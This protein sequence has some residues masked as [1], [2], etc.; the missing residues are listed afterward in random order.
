MAAAPLLGHPNTMGVCTPLLVCGSAHHVALQCVG[1]CLLPSP[2][3]Q[4]CGCRVQVVGLLGLGLLTYNT[5]EAKAPPPI[6]SPKW[7]ARWPEWCIA[8]MLPL[9]A[10]RWGNSAPGPPG[11]VPQNSG[12]AKLRGGPWP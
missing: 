10:A 11:Q 7:A 5:L 12:V 3:A 8:A 9:L 6:A 4:H 2:G 1:E